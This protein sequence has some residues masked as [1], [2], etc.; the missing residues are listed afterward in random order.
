MVSQKISSKFTFLS[1]PILYFTA[2][3]ISF[4]T[5]ALI[6]NNLFISE[7]YI[8]STINNGNSYFTENI[9]K[10][11]ELK[12]EV[13]IERANDNP[14]EI[15]LSTIYYDRKNPEGGFPAKNIRINL[16]YEGLLPI[17]LVVVLTLS[18]PINPKRKIIS[19][20]IGLILM[21]LY[22]VFKL[23]AFAFDNFSEPDYTLVELPYLIGG[24]V[25]Y[26][27]YFISISGYSFNLVIAVIIF[28]VSTLKVKDLNSINDYL[29]NNSKLN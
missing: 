5:I 7:L 9:N 13:K 21:N 22:V 10:K 25:Y 18:I 4:I 28:A 20:L 12:R 19:A 1:S 24:I 29:Q 14:D 23:Y 15:I 11:Y 2:Y 3:F 8:N 17:L 26:Y 6:L 27:N 16:N